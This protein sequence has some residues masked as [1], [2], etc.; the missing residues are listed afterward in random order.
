M[1]VSF[2]SAVWTP[3]ACLLPALACGPTPDRGEAGAGA[4]KPNVLFIVVDTLRADRLGAYGHHR[5]TSPHLDALA[6]EGMRVPRA[7]STAPWT[8]PSIAGLMTSRH[9]SSLGIQSEKAIVAEDAVLLAE[10]L[11]E[12]GYNTAAV[13]SHSFCASDWG[14]DQGF[15]AFDE[16]NVLGHAA[17]TT[18]G[19]TERGKLLLD[20]VAKQDEPWMLW[21]HYFDPHCAYVEDER[22]PMGGRGE[23]DGPVTSGELYRTVLRKYRRYESSDWAELRRLYDSEIARTDAGIGE[24]LDHLARLGVA[25]HTLVVVTADHG[26]E[27]HEHNGVGHAKTLYSEVLHVPLILRFPTAQERFGAALPPAPERW[28]S[29]IDVAP[30][31]LDVAGVELPPS[32]AGRSLL[33]P[34]DDDS[35]MVFGETHRAGGLQTVVDGDFKLIHWRKGR[36]DNLFDLVQDP[37]ET[38][39]LSRDPVHAVI[40]AKLRKALVDHNAEL[41]RAAIEAP[42]VENSPEQ[43]EHLKNLGYA[44]QDD[45]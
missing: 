25:D 1:K 6:N 21:L 24:I 32:F 36:R 41:D 14:F 3:L 37:G 38:K 4:P 42:L 27:F 31:V 35:A 29:L 9:P 30:T 28:I 33:Q 43:V 13:V 23:Y 15:D 10:V 40:L 44:G 11:K 17:I 5:P 18:E 22:F 7:L 26:E 39:D 20:Q 2:S 34:K 8:T 12:A 16:S 19:V 45:E